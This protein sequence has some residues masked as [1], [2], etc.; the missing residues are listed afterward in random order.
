[1]SSLLYLLTSRDAA[2]VAEA[3][4]AV[5]LPLELEWVVLEVV[6]AN[7]DDDLVV[8]VVEHLTTV[9]VDVVVKV[10]PAPVISTV[11]ICLRII[12]FLG[13][14][15]GSGALYALSVTIQVQVKGNFIYTLR[16]GQVVIVTATV[17]VVLSATGSIAFVANVLA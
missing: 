17:T 1:M 3:D 15:V 11:T 14:G 2:L 5:T 8:E 12:S 7:D 16:F 9:E 4:A 13:A 6:V 10:G